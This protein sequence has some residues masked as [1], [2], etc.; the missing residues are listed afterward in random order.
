MNLKRRILLASHALDITLPG[1]VVYS[2]SLSGLYVPLPSCSSR[3]LGDI[4]TTARAD[5]DSAGLATDNT[6]RPEK[7]S[8]GF[9]QSWCWFCGHRLAP[10]LCL[11]CMLVAGRVMPALWVILGGRFLPISCRRSF[12]GV[13][14]ISVAYTLCKNIANNPCILL[15]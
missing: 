7:R 13:L 6:G 3:E 12:L 15:A 2:T 5:G 11:P 4:L 9:T 14:L 10:L 8:C 1:R